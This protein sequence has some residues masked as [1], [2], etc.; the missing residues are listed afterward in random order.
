MPTFS[1][2]IADLQLPCATTATK[3]AIRS[4]LT[5]EPSARGHDIRHLCEISVGVHVLEAPHIV[6]EVRLPSLFALMPDTSPAPQ[7]LL[8]RAC[9]PP[10]VDMDWRDV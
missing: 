1:T 5:A 9:P 3:F 8:Y 2:W 4:A 10:P 6:P 7:L